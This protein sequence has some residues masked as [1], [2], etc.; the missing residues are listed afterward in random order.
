[1]HSQAFTSARN[2]LS[3]DLQRQVL[4]SIRRL[5]S[6]S[7]IGYGQKLP[8]ER[9]MAEELG[10]N[11]LTLRRVFDSLTA[12]GAIVR[13]GRDGT[14]LAFPTVFRPLD[15]DR[16]ESLTETL[17]ADGLRPGGRLL[18]YAVEA[19]SPGV[20]AALALA[21]KA[22][23]LHLCRQRSVDGVP[24]CIETSFL[25]YALVG[26]LSDQAVMAAP[27]LYA[28]L[29]KRFGIRPAKVDSTIEL[30]TADS[31]AVLHLSVSPGHPLLQETAI[32][33]DGSGRPLEFLISVND[34]RIV[35]YRSS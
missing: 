7:R 35:K 15:R 30:V 9:D 4:D 3:S 24:F 29:G 21:P 20:A 2:T 31:E 17:M 8:A 13:N 33:R 25:D 26:D 32:V 1:M 14:R 34:P 28:L 22:R 19:A 11:R 23:V 16:A 10:V 18:H 5:I 6:E 12:A 27:S